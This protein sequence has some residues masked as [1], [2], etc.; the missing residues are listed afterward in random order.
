[1][2]HA[3]CEE[4][5]NYSRAGVAFISNTLL[6]SCIQWDLVCLR[7]RVLIV[8]SK[9]KGQAPKTAKRTCG[10]AF[11]CRTALQKEKNRSWRVCAR[12]C[13]CVRTTN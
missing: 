8:K 4:A 1:M 7:A 10:H 3:R 12:A 13:L 9:H 5:A 2:T 11:R 6:A